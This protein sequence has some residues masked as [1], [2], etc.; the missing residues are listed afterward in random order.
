MASDRPDD[1]LFLPASS[2][3]EDRAASP[4]TQQKSYQNPHLNTN[5]SEVK[6]RGSSD[7]LLTAKESAQLDSAPVQLL[8]EPA[9]QAKQWSPVWIRRRSRSPGVMSH[10]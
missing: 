2:L 7:C 10:R 1:H 5:R 9:V 6:V 3:C 8:P 4:E